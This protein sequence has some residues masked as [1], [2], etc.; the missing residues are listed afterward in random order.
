VAGDLDRVRSDGKLGDAQPFQ[1]RLPGHRIGKLFAGMP[2]QPGN[3]GP[4][5]CVFAHI[6]Q[7]SIV[8]HVIGVPGPQQIEEVQA[9]FA[10]RAAEPAEVVVTDLRA[11]AV[12]A[13]VARASVIHFA[14]NLIRVATDRK[15]IKLRRKIA[16]WDPNY[17]AECLGATTR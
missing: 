3:G 10:T 16:G 13:F 9:A 12:G 11:E 4:G 5:E 8:N 14:I 7:G 6:G 17:L 2:S 15:S 1:M